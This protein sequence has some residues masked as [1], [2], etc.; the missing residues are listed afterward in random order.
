MSGSPTGAALALVCGTG[1]IVYG[2]TIT[3]ELIRAGGWGYLF[4]DEGSGYAIGVAALRAVM[5]AYDGRGQKT[6]LSQL[7]LDQYHLQTPPELVTKLYGT[8]FQ[9]SVAAGLS[10][11]VERAAGLHDPVAMGI[12]EEAGVDLARMI[13]AIYPKIGLSPVPLTVTGGAILPSSH[14]RKAFTTACEQQELS[15]SA[16]HHV[17]EPAQAALQLAGQLAAG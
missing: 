15:F 17:E 13:A 16:I 11:L 3:G 8:K 12:L 5:Q 7:V 9:P 1:S 4:G 10:E 2:R 6:T 14:L